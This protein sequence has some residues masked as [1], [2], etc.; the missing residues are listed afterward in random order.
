MHYSFINVLMINIG[1]IKKSVTINPSNKI[2]HLTEIVIRE[3]SLLG[4]QKYQ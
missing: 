2:L 1:F 4:S 3:Q